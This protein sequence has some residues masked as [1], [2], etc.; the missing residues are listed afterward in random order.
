[1]WI[2]MRY[3]STHP[4]ER[5]GIFST[6]EYVYQKIE[7]IQK[8]L[9]GRSQWEVDELEQFK[10]S[11]QELKQIVWSKACEKA[12]QTSSISQETIEQIIQTLESTTASEFDTNKS[13]YITIFNRINEE[14]DKNC[15]ST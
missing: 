9:H 12:I 13:K 5:I 14:I 7:S 2:S 1:M 4:A 10:N 15:K 8:V 11:F 3:L 6:F